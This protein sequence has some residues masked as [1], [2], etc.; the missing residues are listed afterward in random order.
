MRVIL[1]SLLG[2]GLFLSPAFKHVN[3]TDAKSAASSVSGPR[4]P[5]LDAELTRIARDSRREL[6]RKQYAAQYA[7]YDAAVAYEKSRAESI[8]SQVQKYKEE[9]RIRQEL[10]SRQATYHWVI[11]IVV[12]IVVLAGV[13]MS[14]LQVLSFARSPNAGANTLEISAQGVKIKSPVV[15]LVALVLSLGFFYLY[16][17]DVYTLKSED[18]PTRSHTHVSAPAAE[19]AKPVAE[20]K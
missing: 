13:G 2:L 15:G 7:E 1:I 8:A 6:L 14:F 4:L 17:K 11:L 12:V 3:A 18:D 20:K 16:L 9:N 5:E 10:Y 19:P